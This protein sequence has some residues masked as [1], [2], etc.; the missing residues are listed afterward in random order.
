MNKREMVVS[1]AYNDSK[2]KSVIN[3]ENLE[4]L[5]VEELKIN[6]RIVT[7]VKVPTDNLFRGVILDYPI[8]DIIV[9]NQYIEITGLIVGKVY[10]NLVL[11]LEYI[12]ENKFYLLEDFFVKNGDIISEYICRTY[13]LAF[14]RDITEEEFNEWYFR[15]QKE[16]YAI[17]EFIKSIVNNKEFLALNQEFDQFIDVLY[18]LVSRRKIDT[19]TF[20]EWKKFYDYEISN[21]RNDE[22]IK[23]DIINKMIYFKQF[24]YLVDENTLLE[25]NNG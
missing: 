25:D 10:S 13:K 14:K 20:N 16:E 19:D 9:N 11:N 24:E 18:I 21:G 7:C 2:E 15:L 8:I 1:T 22:D 6:S 17:N 3:I 12:D 4:R 23:L 5:T